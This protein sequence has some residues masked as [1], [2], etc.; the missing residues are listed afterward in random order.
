MVH[1]KWFTVHGT[2]YM[3]CNAHGRHIKDAKKF[4][5]SWV[6]LKPKKAMTTAIAELTLLYLCSTETEKNPKKY[7]LT[8]GLGS[9]PACREAM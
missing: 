6:L 9:S 7:S 2:Q 8:L 4:E 5:F 1:G 3:E